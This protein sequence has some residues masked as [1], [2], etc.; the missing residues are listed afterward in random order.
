VS[1]SVVG[2]YP[3]PAGA[4]ESELPLD[5]WEALVAANPVLTRL[6]PDGEALV[7]NRLSEPPQYMI[8]PIDRCYEL[9][10]LIRTRW[11]GI[12]GGDALAEAVPAFFER[13]RGQATPPP[14]GMAA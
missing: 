13:V 7:A 12:S 9:V 1:G 2:F 14:N 10:G 5:S 6:D 4:T 11:E 3:S 8:L